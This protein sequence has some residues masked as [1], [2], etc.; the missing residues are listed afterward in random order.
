MW[1]WLR[2]YVGGCS[3]NWEIADESSN[4]YVGLSALY[5]HK[6]SSRTGKPSST[7]PK[8][9][10]VANASNVFKTPRRLCSICIAKD[11]NHESC[12]RDHLVNVYHENKVTRSRLFYCDVHDGQYNRP[13][14]GKVNSH[15]FNLSDHRSYSHRDFKSRSKKYLA[16]LINYNISNGMRL[17]RSARSKIA[18]AGS[19]HLAMMFGPLIVESGIPRYAPRSK[20][21]TSSDML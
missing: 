13:N 5:H 6:E 15:Q 1:Q 20:F 9:Q 11:W 3:L 21:R 19:V 17:L 16:P 14:S 10:A 8:P 12:S 4:P 18:P 2:G 7:D